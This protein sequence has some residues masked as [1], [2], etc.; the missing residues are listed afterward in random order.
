MQL[1]VK[2]L[3]D[4]FLILLCFQIHFNK[5]KIEPKKRKET[6]IALVPLP[7][8]DFPENGL[9]DWHTGSVILKVSQIPLLH[10]IVI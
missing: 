9:I 5:G 7:G 6:S 4:L 1:G 3:G 2:C 8:S 10:N